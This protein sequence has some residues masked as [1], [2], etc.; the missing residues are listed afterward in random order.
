MTTASRCAAPR[1]DN[2]KAPPRVRPR[3]QGR[4]AVLLTLLP[5]LA[6]STGCVQMAAVW[7]NIT[8]GDVVE[9]EFKLTK[10]PL[11]I[12][13]DDPNSLITEPQAVRDLHKAMAAIFLEFNV[14]RQVVPFENWQTFQR[15]AK[16]YNRL[17]VREIG[18]KLGAVQVLYLGVDRFTLQA[19]PGAPIYKGEFAVRVKVLSTE[20][21]RDVRLWPREEAGR[22][23]AVTTQP[24]PADGDVSAADVARELAEKL[25][26][27]V[28]RLFYEHR[29]LDK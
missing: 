7:A 13:I 27:A 28:A 18:E 14:N 11:L 17:S 23:I 21:K 3:G 8:G 6:C 26:D 15:T 5:V 2:A 16:N 24:T 22:R 25:A 20:P 29:A 19:E 12:L 10:E 1:S 4:R 9:P